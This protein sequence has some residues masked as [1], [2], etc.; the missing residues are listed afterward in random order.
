MKNADPKPNLKK[1]G[2]G[3]KETLKNKNQNPEIVCQ[4]TIIQI[5]AVIIAQVK[6]KRHTIFLC[7]RNVFQKHSYVI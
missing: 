3:K 5:N 2:K 6:Q 4:D 1:K 7:K